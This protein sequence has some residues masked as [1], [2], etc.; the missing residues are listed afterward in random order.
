MSGKAHKAGCRQ[1]R[2][3]LHS[4][5]A[6]I[7]RCDMICF[8]QHCSYNSNHCTAAIS[9]TSGKMR[10]CAYLVQP[11]ASRGARIHKTSPYLCNEQIILDTIHSQMADMLYRQ[12]W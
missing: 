12:M 9:S 3:G 8:V 11:L 6:R 1:H 5:E 4:I 7:N 2:L 10:C